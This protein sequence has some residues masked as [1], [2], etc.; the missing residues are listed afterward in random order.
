MAVRTKLLASGRS[1]SATASI[2]YTVPADETAIL[3]SIILCNINAST[4]TTIQIAVDTAANNLTLFWEEG[5][6][7]RK[8]LVIEPYLVLQPGMEVSLAN[9]A[10]VGVNYWVSGVELEGI[11]D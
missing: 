7:A 1:S 5:L 8:S 2:I 3:K 11:A 4:T 6:I 9:A 10:A